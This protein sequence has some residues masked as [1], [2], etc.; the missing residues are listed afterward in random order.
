M[1]NY[2]QLD[3]CSGVWKL[4][5]VYDAVMGGYWRNHGSRGIFSGGDTEP[6]AVLNVIDFVTLASAGNAADFGDLT[7]ARKHQSACSSFTR[8]I[9]LGGSSPN[10]NIMDY[11]TIMTQGNAADFG[12]ISANTSFMAAA[13]N[14]IRGIRMGG[15]T[16][17]RVNVIEYITMTATGN[18]TDFGDLTQSVSEPM[19]VTSPTRAIRCG[20]STGSYTNTMDSVEIM[21]TGNA[22]DFGDLAYADGTSGGNNSS[23]TRGFV[24]AGYDGS[25]YVTHIQKVE[26]K[27][28]N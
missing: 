1:A 26:M 14:A 18:T 12:D 7:E 6:G 19:T 10:K 24:S 25:G 15:S 11:V 4:H 28:W 22:V 27:Y 5:E 23:S 16:P 8:H 21:T 13:S 20:G 9:H 17:S 2:P 3:D